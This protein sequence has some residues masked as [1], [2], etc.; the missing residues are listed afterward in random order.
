MY[1][2]LPWPSVTIS[3]AAIL[4]WIEE[5]F[6]IPI[7]IV[8]IM[9]HLWSRNQNR[10]S[11]LS[12]SPYS[13][14]RQVSFTALLVSKIFKCRSIELHHC[15]K[16]GS[17]A[18]GKFFPADCYQ[19]PK[20]GQCWTLVFSQQAR[21]TELCLLRWCWP[22]SASLLLGVK[23]DITAGDKTQVLWL[24]QMFVEWSWQ[25]KIICSGHLVGDW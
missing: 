11:F 6:G 2:I 3:I 1:F 12:T 23:K 18:K 15:F 8:R 14:D 22:V 13:S 9:W 24:L 4:F 7:L 17:D 10:R 5:T 25:Q 21:V 16:S 20:K 19:E